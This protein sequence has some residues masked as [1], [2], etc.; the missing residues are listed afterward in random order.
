M[1]DLVTSILLKNDEFK[2]FCYFTKI[3][4]NEGDNII[5]HINFIIKTDTQESSNSN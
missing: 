1:G 4:E 5:N 2:T 3:K